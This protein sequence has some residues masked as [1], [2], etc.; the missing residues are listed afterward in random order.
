[1]VSASVP[2]ND[3]PTIQ[4][5]PDDSG[6][7]SNSPIVEINTPTLPDPPDEENS[8]LTHPER[9]HFGTRIKP[10]AGLAEYSNVSQDYL[11]FIF[12][13][14]NMAQTTL[15][16]DQEDK[17]EPSA[18][19]SITPA[20]LVSAPANSHAQ[21]VF[22]SSEQDI[23][24]SHHLLKNHKSIDKEFHV[25]WGSSIMIV[26]SIN[27]F[28]ELVKCDEQIHSIDGVPVSG[29]K[30]YRTVIFRFG[31]QLLPV[32]EVA[33]MPNNPQSTFTSSHLQRVNS[34]LPGIHS[35]HSSVK[36]IDRNGIFTKLIPTK[37]NGLDYITISLV[38][39]K[40]DPTQQTRFA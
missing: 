9:D 7:I 6:N 31:S 37:R 16:N 29:I 30:G 1:M 2:V 12:P 11:Y 28:T 25:D 32:R 36:V 24:F 26:N 8:L 33:F 40:D 27:A 15:V 21:S 23:F 3:K 14:G 22:T 13:S 20:A 39:P 17:N 5:S 4:P 19:N 34:F 35:L 10:L 18:T 38:V